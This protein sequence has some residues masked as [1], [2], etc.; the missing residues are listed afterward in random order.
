MAGIQDFMRKLQEQDEDVIYSTP[1]EDAIEM[2]P[3]I[4]AISTVEVDIPHTV[5][6]IPPEQ[7]ETPRPVFRAN[8][9]MRSGGNNIVSESTSPLSDNQENPV[10]P[11]LN[12]KLN[13]NAVATRDKIADNIVQSAI[14]DLFNESGTPSTKK[15][16]WITKFNEAKS[17]KKK[18]YVVERMRLGKF[19]IT[20]NNEVLLLP[21]LDIQGKSS[22]E[23]LREQWLHN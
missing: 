21:D 9:S 12:F 22:S 5:K 6:V 10:K 8:F 16:L 13:I 11:K 19:L 17:S 14:E 3:P 23:I 7:E 1:K 2:I 15:E 20:E 4:N 18:N